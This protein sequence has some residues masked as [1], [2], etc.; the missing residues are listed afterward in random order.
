VRD[1]KACGVRPTP[2]RRRWL[3]LLRV[4][5]VGVLPMLC[6]VRLAYLQIWMHRDYLPLV[7]KQMVATVE[8]SIPRGDI[9]DR[10]G[11]LVATTL[12]EE[13][14][15]VNT[16]EF[17]AGAR[18]NPAVWDAVCDALGVERKVF[19]RR[20][21]RE[22]YFLVK[23]DVPLSVSRSLHRIRG[24]DF[25]RTNRRVYPHGTLAAHA[26]G[27]MG[28][29]NRGYA[30]VEKYCDGWLAAAT[31]R[32]V[33]V[34]RQGRSRRGTARL[35][36]AADAVAGETSNC[37][38]TLT[39]DMRL[40]YV[41]E[42][43]LADAYVSRDPQRVMC[44]VQE[45]ATGEI[46][47]MAVHPPTEFPIS[48]PIVHQVFEPGSTFKAFSMAVFLQEGAVK[49]DTV[50]DCE[51]GRFRYAGHTVSDVH[52]NARLTMVEVMAK[53]SNI[54][55]AK[56]W[57]L[58]ADPDR[59]CGALR[60]FGFG[61]LTGVELPGEQK[62]RVPTPQMSGWSAYQPV[63]MSFGQGVSVTALQMVNAYS[64]LANG[65]ALMQ[66]RLV[67]RI[68]DECGRVVYEGRPEV[69]RRPLHPEV[70]AAIR[71][72][73]HEVV[74]SGSA[75]GARLPDVAVC[76]KTGTAQKYDVAAGGY[77]MSRS[78]I[79]VCGFFP[80]ESP[81]YTVGIFFDEPRRGR[82]ASDVAVPYFKRIVRELLDA[83]RQVLYAQAF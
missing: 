76:A 1:R 51:N 26:V 33:E 31:S 9:F 78:L 12:Q 56:A 44:V 52:P 2:F 65:G 70:V 22:R 64:M 7:Y 60:L 37:T 4:V 14:V 73:L 47:V 11:R 53:S 6:I 29:D 42:K 68:T 62:G 23:A 15:Y 83:D 46:L 34:F 50:V 10:S 45:P 79:S 67:K 82:L 69:I 74:E 35:V 36:N 28:A 18:C 58:Y 39:L 25:V 75:V 40:Q 48:N 8:V 43:V 38:V 17:T 16:A 63:A 72:M 80:K 20:I 30:G 81:R 5:F 19:A 3:V 13:S 57:L 24:L 71:E 61:S 66:P 41:V 32:A 55:M 54:G 77:S 59:F 21:N 27:R 49:P